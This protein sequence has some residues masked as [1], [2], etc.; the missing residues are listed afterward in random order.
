MRRRVFAWLSAKALAAILGG[1]ALLGGPAQVAAQHQQQRAA[2]L[3]PDLRTLD[4]GP[5][6][7]CQEMRRPVFHRDACTGSG[8]TVLRVNTLTG[9]FGKGPLELAAVRPAQDHPRDCHNDGRHDINGDGR[10]D[11]NDIVVKQRV[12]KDANGDGAFKRSVDRKR[13]SHRVGCRYYHPAHHHYHLAAFATFNL[14]SVRTGRTVRRSGK[15]SFCLNDTGP[16]NRSLPGAQH[17]DGYYS[18]RRCAVRRSVQ[19]VSIGWSDTYGWKTPG[20]ELHVKG[21]PKGDYCLITKADPNNHVAESHE[22]N[23]KRRVRYHIDPAKAPRN[24]SQTLTPKPG[25]CPS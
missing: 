20:Q 19:G 17:G 3:L 22:S 23:N 8:R 12:Y 21:L 4:P 18:Y 2:R 15:V 16:F 25:G 13:Q 10:P 1:A 5:A 11:D 7:L 6:R 9:N 24:S 14:K